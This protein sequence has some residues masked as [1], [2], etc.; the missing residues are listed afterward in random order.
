MPGKWSRGCADT[1]SMPARLGASAIFAAVLVTSGCVTAPYRTLALAFDGPVPATLGYDAEDL[2]VAQV[3]ARLINDRL[4]LPFPAEATV[5]VYVNQATFAEGL[6]REGGLAE[7]AA[8]DRAAFAGGVASPRGIFLRGDILASMR[9]PDRV[10]LIAHELAHVCQ[11]EMR[12]GGSGGPATWIL[13]GHADWV[14]YRVIDFLGLRSYAQSRREVRRA[15]RLAVIRFFPRL[16]DLRSGDQW[17]QTRNRLGSAATYGQA[18]LAVDWIA[19]RYGIE[20]LD[21]F[22]RRFAFR[23]DPT[24]HWGAV[25]PIAYSQFVRE[26]QTHLEQLPE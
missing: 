2:R 17:T 13:E 18:F 14:K 12:R 5:H 6:V 22:Q 20:K 9:L 4:G 10:G 24:Q 19:E 26:F 11:M 3:A 23:T 15:V 16:T 25:F 21:E 1:P 7:T 8:W